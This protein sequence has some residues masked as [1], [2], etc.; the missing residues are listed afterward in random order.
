MRMNRAKVQWHVLCHKLGATERRVDRSKA[1]QGSP[2]DGTLH[3][4]RLSIKFQEIVDE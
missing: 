4:V 2:F 1:L 3:F